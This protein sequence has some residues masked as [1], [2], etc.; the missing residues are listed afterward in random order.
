MPDWTQILNR[1][2]AVAHAEDGYKLA[3]QPGVSGADLD[4]LSDLLGIN[5]PDEFREFYMTSNGFGVATDDNPNDACWLFRPL[6]DL[7]NFIDSVR[8]S[9]SETHPDLASR[10][11]PFIDWD[12]GDGMGYLTE[13]TDII[14]P[15]LFCFEHES[16][17]Y[18]AD[19]DPDEFIS[20]IPVTIEEFLSAE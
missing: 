17:A 1:H 13:T 5:L 11:F 19:Q 10:F 7:P 14:L 15:G 20:V 9:F 2:H 16:Y 18:S 8:S 3:T 4:R 6:E 12:N